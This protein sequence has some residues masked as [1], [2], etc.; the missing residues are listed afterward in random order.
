MFALTQ[1]FDIYRLS[2]NGPGYQ[3]REFADVVHRFAIKFKNDISRLYSGLFPIK[4]T[5]ITYP[6]PRF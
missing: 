2:N 3:A 1:K 6:L 5:P 4:P